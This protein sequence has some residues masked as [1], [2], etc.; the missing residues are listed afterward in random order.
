[1]TSIDL[2]DNF[3]IFFTNC[4]LKTSEY[5]AFAFDLSTFFY[6]NDKFYWSPIIFLS[7]AIT[8]SAPLKED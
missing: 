6:I 1:M 3:A 7:L 5:F 2:D 8:L 4:F